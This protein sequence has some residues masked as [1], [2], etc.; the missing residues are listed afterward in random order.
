[1]WTESERASSVPAGWLGAGQDVRRRAA[2]RT[3]G[4]A[5]GQQLA[6]V[7]ESDYAVAEK[8]PPLLRKARHDPRRIAVGSVSG[9]TGGLVLAHRNSELGVF[10]ELRWSCG[11]HQSNAHM[12]KDARYSAKRRTFEQVTRNTFQVWPFG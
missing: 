4:A 1:M 6:G 11:C 5:V 8:A 7:L 2:V 9:G 12:T 10:V 3:D